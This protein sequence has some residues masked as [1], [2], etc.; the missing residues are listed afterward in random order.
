MLLRGL[1]DDA[2][3]T[4]SDLVVSKRFWMLLRS[5]GDDAA[6]QPLSPLQEGGGGP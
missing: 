3:L 6:K 2:A 1:G 4:N 5:F